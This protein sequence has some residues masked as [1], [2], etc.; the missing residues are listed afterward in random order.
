MLTPSTMT[1]VK[2]RHHGSTTLR[3]KL[4]KSACGISRKKAAFTIPNPSAS[5]MKGAMNN[6]N[7]QHT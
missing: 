1:V 3:T 4:E 2:K 7:S 5:D 6:N